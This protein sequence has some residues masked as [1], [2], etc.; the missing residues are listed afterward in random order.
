MFKRTTKRV[1]QNPA[2]NVVKLGATAILAG[3][4]TGLQSE[5]Y[6]SGGSLDDN[7]STSAKIDEM[8]NLE[9][10]ITFEP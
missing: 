6:G 5:S 9:P 10:T 3:S 8:L 4:I 7:F 1:Y 2:I